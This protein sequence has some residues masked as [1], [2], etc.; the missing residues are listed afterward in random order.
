[1]KTFFILLLCLAATLGSAA[2]QFVIRPGQ[3]IEVR[4]QGV[5]NEEMARVNNT[6]PVSEAGTIR[7]PFIGNVRAAGRSPNALAGAIESAYRGAKIYTNP[8]VQVLASSDDELAQ[9]ILTVGGQV[10]SPGPVKWVRGMTL[11][12]A[13]QTA[14]GETP[15]G[16]IRRIRLIRDGRLRELDLKKTETKGFLVKPNDTIEVPQKNI[17]GR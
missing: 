8:T 17:F 6:Y 1:M 12:Q 14:G 15:F 16:T 3:A 13:L 11:Y 2:A 9:N 10:K 5:P 7:M 4:I